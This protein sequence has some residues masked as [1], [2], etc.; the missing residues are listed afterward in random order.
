MSFLIKFELQELNMAGNL[1]CKWQCALICNKYAREICL[2]GIRSFNYLN[3]EI[4]IMDA[5]IQSDVTHSPDFEAWITVFEFILREVVPNLQALKT[6]KYA[7]KLLPS[8]WAD[9]VGRRNAV[10]EPAPLRFSIP[11]FHTGEIRHWNHAP[12]SNCITSRLARVFICIW[13]IEPLRCSHPAVG[14]FT[15]CFEDKWLGEE[16]ALLIFVT[17]VVWSNYS[18]PYLRQSRGCDS[19]I[20]VDPHPMCVGQHP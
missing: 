19:S 18:H 10:F 20:F 17:E 16:I 11:A 13:W 12:E 4:F 14:H 6:R 5:C 2:C 8:I 1:R 15:L 3:N 9:T 7:P